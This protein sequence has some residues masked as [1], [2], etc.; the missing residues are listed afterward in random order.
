MTQQP[1]LDVGTENIP[2]T[3]PILPLF[4]VALFPK[5]VLPIVVMPGDSILLVDEAMSKDRIIGLL[6]S[7]KTQAE[8]VVNPDDLYGIGTSA[9][10]LKMAKAPDNRAQLLVQGLGRFQVEKFIEGGPYLKA[11]VRNLKEEGQKDKEVEALMANLTAQFT[12]VVE[13]SPGLPQ[14]IIAMAKSIH[15]PGILADMVASTINSTA[16]EKQHVLEILS[17]KD[18]LTE[19]TRLV[20]Y[21]R[22]VMELGNKIQSQVKGDMDKRQREYYLRQQLKAIRDELGESDDGNVE[23]ED[24]RAKI[25]AKKLPEEAQ[26]EAKRELDRL[27]RMHPSSSE[28]TVA[29]TYLDWLTALPWHE[30]TE[31][32]LDIAK[33]RK[34]LDDDH[35]GLEKA[36]KRILEYLAVRKLKPDSKGP[37]LCFVG[38]PGT[39]KTSL[40]NS[41]ARALG[42]KFIRLSLGGV[43]DEAEIRGHRRTYVGALPGRIIQGI[44]R[45]ESNN[46]VFMLDEIDKVGSDFRGDPSS[47]LLEVLDPEQN[48]TFQDH[49][50]DV[51]FDLSKV[52]FIT[53]ANV[54]DTIPPPLRDRMEVLQLLG[55]TEDEKIQIANRYLIPRQ[56]EAHGLTGKHITFNKAAIKK[57]ITGYTREA[58]L[59]NLER[60]IASVCRGVAAKVAEGVTES[61][62]ITADNLSE[63]IGSVRISSDTKARTSTPGVATGLAWTPVGGEL[64]FIEAT[65]MPGK[66][67]LTLTGQLGDVMKESA[68]AALSFIRSNAKSLGIENKYI[69]EHDLHI[70][71]PAGA[72]P[73]DGPSAGVTMLTALTSLM[74]NRKIKK[75]LAMTGEIT[76]RGLVLPVGG[77]KEKVLAAHRAGIKTL[78]LP[79]WNEKDLEDIPEKVKKDITFHFVDKM[80]EVLDIALGDK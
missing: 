44:R 57:I 37:I 38:P 80:R 53:T 28:Y 45:A 42:R 30:A 79:K 34:V 61:V 71:V 41:I 3:L 46:P 19:V 17:I 74:T 50:L 9:L 66:R 39:G 4:D 64:L 35:F 65:A 78:I 25:E 2:E 40:G 56:R 22:D 75:D 18:R 43:R 51:A 6:A 16:E 68:Q 23:V 72:I 55:Y 27:A 7:K 5:M 13:L 14:E 1:S 11:Q 73:K 12:R 77:I 15:E 26:K 8:G 67:N 76:L 59:R 69:E 52:M 29:S 36:K 70:H 20:N 32:N 58:G 60:E 21:Q 31:D 10:I 49:Y 63:Y 33:A 47:A 54:L 48:F 62:S 24:Y